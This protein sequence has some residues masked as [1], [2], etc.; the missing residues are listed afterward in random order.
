[1]RLKPKK[2][3][4]YYKV[5][6]NRKRQKM[7]KR[8]AQIILASLGISVLSPAIEVQAK[9]T[10]S[11]EQETKD[12]NEELKEQA[13]KW[14]LKALDFFVDANELADETI[15]DPVIDTYQ[16]KK[17]YKHE[18]LWLIT[19]MPNTDPKEARH[20]YF[21]KKKKTKIPVT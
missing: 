21:V 3:F 15:T 10:T 12:S 6:E 20:F 18:E 13:K 9:E 14:G 5:N 19:D 4:F 1:M 16:E 17:T 8:T 2:G 7:N 11:V